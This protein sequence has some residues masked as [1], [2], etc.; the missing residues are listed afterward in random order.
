MTPTQPTPIQILRHLFKPGAFATGIG[1]VKVSVIG[2]VGGAGCAITLTGGV[3]GGW[4]FILGELVTTGLNPIADTA[5]NIAERLPKFPHFA[6]GFRLVLAD[7]E[8]LRTAETQ[9]VEREARRAA[10]WGD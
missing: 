8:E 7:T 2:A 4:A 1:G 9:I 10:L 3:F 5:Y 6:E